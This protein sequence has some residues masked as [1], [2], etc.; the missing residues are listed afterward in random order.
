M[1]ESRALRIGI[2]AGEMSGDLLGA[3]LIEQLRGFHPT[4][5][6]EGIG[7]EKM[8][9]AGLDN[10]YP[11]EQLSIMGLVEV[12][13]HLP[14]LF[15]LKRE[16]LER[17]AANPP[18]LFIGV[19]APDFNLRI[20]HAL[21][22][23]GVP[24]VHYVSPSVWAW[25]QGRVVGIRRS[26]DLMLTLLPFEADFYRQHGVP[27]AH[28]GH[29]MA[30]QIPWH[31]DQGEARERLGLRDVS[32]PVVALLPGS[33][34]SE[35]R[36][37]LG[38]FLEAATVFARRHPG[39]LFLLPA[40][41]SWRHAQMAAVLQECGVAHR[42]YLGQART[43]MAAA[44]SVVL[45]SGTA[46]LECMLVKRPMVVAY[47]LAPLTY[48]IMRLMIR[49]RYVSLPN[50]LAD[51]PLVPELLQHQAT[52]ANI[53]SELEKS[54]DPASRNALRQRFETL[55]RQ[56]R[57]DADVRAAQAVADLLAR[58]GKGA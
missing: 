45:A 54:L 41:N 15:R 14:A 51:A 17:W 44:D 32:G 7:G 26:T 27:V 22:Q 23:R 3:G 46:T 20:E 10:W 42:L 2:I 36:L 11:M 24:T 25:R 39:A 18:D 53:A 1:G 48:W 12:L 58:T 4:A 35:V 50:L 55:H 40:A 33:R 16:L 5:R 13:R 34:A 49:S 28:V 56:L 29:P 6:F 19:D 43:C 9:A 52:P 8:I 31:S 57:L 38:V 37:L 21:H 30:D 47:R